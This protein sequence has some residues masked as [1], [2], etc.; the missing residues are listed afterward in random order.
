MT[1]TTSTP[2]HS[3]ADLDHLERLLARGIKVIRVVHSDLFGRQRAKQFPVS[4]LK[5]ILDGVA[6][7]K[8][9]VAED[10]FG[11]PVDEDQFPQLKGHPDLHARIAPGSAFIP[12]WEPDA[13][14]VMATL[15]EGD[16]RSQ[17][18]ARGQLEDAIELLQETTGLTGIAAGE[19]EFYL[20]ERDAQ[21]RAT[22]TPYSQEGV[23]YTIDRITDQRGVLARMYRALIDFGIGVT[24]VNREF[25]P[26]QFEINVHHAPSLAAADH[27][28]LLK[29]GI[30]ELAIIEGCAANF[31]AKPLSGEEGSSLHFHLSLWND[32]QNVFDD[33]GALS[34]TMRFAL[35]GIQSHAAAL[36]A[37]SS[38]TVNSYKRLHGEGLSPDT[39]NW[40][41]DT[42]YSYLRIPAERA[43]AT[44]LELR[45]GDASA[46]PYLLLA[47]MLHAVRDGIQQRIEPTE[48]GV[49]LPADLGEAVAALD[50][51]ALFGE[52]F[53]PEFT[54][55]YGELKRREVRS[56]S[57][58]VTDWEWNLY[59]SAV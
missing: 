33:G 44:R 47:G 3:A 22:R 53:G 10:L 2:A 48:A 41:E 28:F 40:G 19:P 34:D 25:S 56:H 58:A 9:S 20:F 27:I 6:Y 42:R 30:K 26:G 39:S 12:P 37:L 51:D 17:L 43:K 18:C 35:G 23:S 31:M 14:W 36:T 11:V 57:L 13:V 49:Q 59:Q 4:S 46:N 38:P 50:G 54:S 32:E 15:W 16:R 21:G 5:S 29:T 45:A 1:T 52:A 8:M 24:A 55:I 7:S